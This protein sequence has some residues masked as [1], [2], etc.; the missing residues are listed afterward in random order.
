MPGLR[1]FGCGAIQQT[2]LSC[3]EVASETLEN[4]GNGMDKRFWRYRPKVDSISPKGVQD[5]KKGG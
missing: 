1:T 4:G 5:N 3:V 2:L